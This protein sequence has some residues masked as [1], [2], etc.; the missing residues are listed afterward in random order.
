M[1]IDDINIDY[2]PNC[3]HVTNLHTTSVDSTAATIVWQAGGE[4]TEW[5]VIL[6][7]GNGGAIPDEE[8][9]IESIQETPSYTA[10]DL[11]SASFYTIYVRAN[12]GNS[13]SA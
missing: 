13:Y 12:C 1:Y 10:E 11:S 2:I 8:A 3:L 7:E 9:T 6:V 5:E 4:E